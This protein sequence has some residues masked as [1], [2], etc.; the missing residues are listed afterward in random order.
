MGVGVETLR[1]GRRRTV[2]AH[3]AGRFA[4]TDEL[5]NFWPSSTAAARSPCRAGR[6]QPTPGWSGGDRPR[7]PRGEWD[8]R[9]D[10]DRLSPGRVGDMRFLMRT[11]PLGTQVVVHQ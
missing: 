1:R 6:A 11:L 10:L 8:R 5:S 4:V 9:G 7:D 3:A 2:D